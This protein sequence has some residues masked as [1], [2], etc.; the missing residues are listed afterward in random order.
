MPAL[1]VGR[2]SRR[3][4]RK[5]GCLFLLIEPSAGLHPADIANLLDCFDRLL[6]AGHSLIV[7][8]NDPDVVKCA[9]WVIELGPEGGK[10]GGRIVAQGAPN[11]D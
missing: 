1:E 10:A 11:L 2:P 4:V 3:R 5:A 7:T 6:S 9:D 8:D